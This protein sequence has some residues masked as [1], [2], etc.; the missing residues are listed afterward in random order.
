MMLT[1][2]GNIKVDALDP[3]ALAVLEKHKENILRS[4]AAGLDR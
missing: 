3:H 2:S 4:L 1:D